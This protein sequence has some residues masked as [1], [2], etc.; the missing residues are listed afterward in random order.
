MRFF[1]ARGTRDSKFPSVD[2]AI[3]KQVVTR[4]AAYLAEQFM[5]PRDRFAGLYGSEPVVD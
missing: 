4:P 1:G 3:H 5:K 2:P